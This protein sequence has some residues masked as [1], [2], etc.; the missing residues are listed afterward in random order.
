MLKKILSFILKAFLLLL[1]FSLHSCYN[2][3]VPQVFDGN[4][5][6]ESP[7]LMTEKHKKNI[8]KVLTYYDED[9]K[10]ENGKILV[11]KNI[12]N[13]IL[14]NYTTKTNDSIWLKSNGLK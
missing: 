2:E 7:K 4:K 5:I 10:L 13:E 12:D 14:W 9:W 11:S 3:Y 1:V 6:V 8:V